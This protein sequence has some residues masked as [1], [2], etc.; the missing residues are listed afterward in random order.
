[1]A[2]VFDNSVMTGNAKIDEQHKMLFD[3]INNLLDACGKGKGRAEIEKTLIFLNDYIATHFADEEKLQMQYGYPDYP[4]HKK[5]H[6]GYK[7]VV[8]DIIDEF[9]KDGATLVLLGKVNSSIATW[10]VNHI[11]KE[12]V[13]VAAHI[14]NSSK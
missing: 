11:K 3:A 6:E 4:Q 7:Q 10:L 1:M 13:K 12:D 14:K 8:R 5:Y 2:Y 9:K